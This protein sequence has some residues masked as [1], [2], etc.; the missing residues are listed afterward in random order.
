[1]DDHHDVHDWLHGWSYESISPQEAKRHMQILG[2]DLAC[3]FSESGFIVVLDYVDRDARAAEQ[4][5]CTVYRT[6]W[7][8]ART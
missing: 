3:P 8:A 1:M 7:T 6:A 4:N 2:F 5:H